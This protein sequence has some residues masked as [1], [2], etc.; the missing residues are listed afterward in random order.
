MKHLI[1][2]LLVIL[3]C[4]NLFAGSVTIDLNKNVSA[5]KEYQRMVDVFLDS[6]E[7]DFNH[8][9]H[10]CE[11]TPTKNVS[12]NKN[13][14]KVDVTADCRGSERNDRF[15][16]LVDANQWVSDN[17]WDGPLYVERVYLQ[18]ELRRRFPHIK[19]TW[20]SH[21][22]MYRVTINPEYDMR[23]SD[24]TALFFG[25]RVN[26]HMINDS[27][28]GYVVKFPMRTFLFQAFTV[29]K[30]KEYEGINGVYSKKDFIKTA[31]ITYRLTNAALDVI[32]ASDRIELAVNKCDHIW[33]MPEQK[34]YM[35]K[36]QYRHPKL[37]IH[38]VR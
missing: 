34:G 14:L 24:Q 11:V 16:R 18:K 25:V 27:R 26:G 35:N 20:V 4:N 22:L 36:S 23:G 38:F 8:P 12:L 17:G 13:I 1:A 30:T 7:Y 31:T 10:W 33:V 15:Q 2:T 37:S 3:F 6:M 32:N 29:P 9:M 28:Y 21:Q 19:M 5:T